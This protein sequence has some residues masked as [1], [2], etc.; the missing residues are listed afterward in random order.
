MAPGDWERTAVAALRRADSHAL[1]L[2]RFLR[3]RQESKLSCCLF[4]EELLW[5][6]QEGL[7]AAGPFT[8]A[9]GSLARS[10]PVMKAG[11]FVSGAR[12]PSSPFPSVFV[13]K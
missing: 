1:W 8:A 6:S 5:G 13:A 9:L 4:T 2:R 11:T 3:T 7:V 10:W 12:T